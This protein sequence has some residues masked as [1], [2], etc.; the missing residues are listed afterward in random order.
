MLPKELSNGVCSLNPNEDKL[1]LSVVMNVNSK[2]NVL[3]HEIYESIIRSNNI[4]L[5]MVTYN[6]TKRKL[7]EI[8]IEDIEVGSLYKYILASSYLP[9][10]NAEKIDGD[11]YIDGGFFNNLPIDLLVKKGYKKIISVRLRPDKY[12]YS[13][14]R[15]IDIVDI[16]PREPLG[17]TLDFNSMKIKKNIELGY[18]DAKKILSDTIDT[19]IC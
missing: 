19:F 6:L 18:S 4:E 3:K 1:T 15:N 17:G 2:G 11:Y 13:I 16:S 9:V 10:F 5:G 7:K 12:D 8:F 14:Y